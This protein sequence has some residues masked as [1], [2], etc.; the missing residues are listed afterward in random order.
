MNYVA[1]VDRPAIER[2]FMAFSTEHRMQFK[3]DDERRIL[4]GPAMLA[5]TPIY[6]KRDEEEFYV[7]FEPA[8]I[9]KIVQKFFLKNY[10]SNFN[11][12]HDEKQAVDDVFVFESFIVDRQR[13]I[14]PMQGFE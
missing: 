13:G 14:P 6:R 8:E 10:H 4:S 11:L 3:T 9:E 5:N 7:V 12:M 1:L 2:H